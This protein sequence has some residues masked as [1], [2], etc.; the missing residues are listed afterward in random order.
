LL[1]RRSAFADK[2]DFVAR[3]ALHAIVAH[4]VLMAIGD[5][6]AASREETRQA[7]FRAPPPTDLLPIRVRQRGFSR[8]G[9]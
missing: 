6:D 9:R 2:P 8:D 5:T 4:T 1:A 3:H 7:A